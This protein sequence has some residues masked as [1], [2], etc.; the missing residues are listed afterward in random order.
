M[1]PTR[2]LPG[3]WFGGL[4][5]ERRVALASLAVLLVLLGAVVLY[6]QSGRTADPPREWRVPVEEP[7]PRADASPEVSSA[8]APG[9]RPAD[10]QSG[11]ETPAPASAPS[12]PEAPPER[13]SAPLPGQPEILKAYHS[14]DEAYGDSRLYTGIAYK[15]APGQS[16]L[17]AARGTVQAVENDPLE[18]TTVVL[19]HGGELTTRYTGMGKVLVAEGASVETGS[20]IGQTGEPGM[21]RTEMG[22]HL[23]F[24]VWL[25][26][27]PVDPAT[28]LSD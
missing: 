9:L 17:A 5:K 22:P 3:S 2:S 12:Q 20:I 25:S 8:G 28:Y 1:K 23:A 18:G 26:D 7:A 19:S 14:V 10:T 6:E 24:A 13:L 4:P 11:A 16:V 15:A 27:E 21:A